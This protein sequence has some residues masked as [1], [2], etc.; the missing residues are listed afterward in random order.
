MNS[1]PSLNDA[2]APARRVRWAVLGAGGIASRRTIPEGLLRSDNAVLTAVHGR[3]PIRN[4][5]LAR[6]FGVRPAATIAD[7]LGND[8]D[9]VYLATPPAGHREQAA[10]CAAAGK[11]VLCEKPLALTV[12]DA[13]AMQADCV[14]HGVLLGTALMM[15]FH[16]Q[17]RAALGFVAGGRL[18]HPVFA[19]AQ[20][21][22]WYPP[23]P[24]AWRQDPAT[25]GGGALMD[26]GGHCIDLLE[27]FFGP[28]TTVSCTLNRI[29]HAYP[30]E[31]GAIVTLRF[32]S[33]ALGVVDT[34][35]CIPDASSRNV[36]EL[37]GS[38]GSIVA[39]GTIGQADRGEMSACLPGESLAYDPRQAREASTALTIDPAPVNLYRAEIEAFSA[40]ILS[41]GIPPNHAGLGL[42]SQ[43]VLAACYASA[44]AGRAIRLDAAGA[45]DVTTPPASAGGTAA[46]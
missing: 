39:R 19:R 25:G 6:R 18:G 44:R 13:E 32:A 8:V 40:A 10:L 20:L 14:R 15:R 35:F 22:C 17:H 34:F 36:L 28:A 46:G 37:Y 1:A 38:A 29:V 4:G 33:G 16:A 23:I 12:A 3:D 24:D 2:R 5:E 11:H 43:R 45:A 31:D 9:A 27:M 21:S 42:R 30:A 41:G 26:L 7:L